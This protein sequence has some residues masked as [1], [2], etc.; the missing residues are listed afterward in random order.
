MGS[1]VI[2]SEVVMVATM[3]SFHI[4]MDTIRT[5]AIASIHSTS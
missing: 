2:M 3:G 1:T 4:L 5:L